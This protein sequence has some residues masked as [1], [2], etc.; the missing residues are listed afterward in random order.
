MQVKA[1]VAEQE[2]TETT[3]FVRRAVNI[4]NMPTDNTFNKAM[5]EYDLTRALQAY[6]E[7]INQEPITA[8]AKSIEEEMHNMFRFANI[9]E[10]EQKREEAD[11]IQDQEQKW[12]EEK[13]QE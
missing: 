2:Q 11:R 12:G 8:M 13:I 7:S 10:A 4:A 1:L 5:A 9:L 6:A 3:S